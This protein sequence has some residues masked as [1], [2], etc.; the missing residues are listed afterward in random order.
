MNSTWRTE[1]GRPD[2]RDVPRTNEVLFDP[3]RHE[4]LTSVRWNADA[5]RA[6]IAAIVDD[7]LARFSPGKLW[8]TH[9]L[10]DEDGDPPPPFTMLYMGAAGVMWALDWLA[11]AGATERRRNFTPMLDDLAARN[12]AQVEPWGH[13]VESLFMGRAGILLLHD[14]L[15][16]SPAIADRLAAS[17][18]ANAN[19]PS[20]ELL[21]GSPG[22]MHAAL[23]MHE[24]TGEDRWADLFRNDART[25]AASFAYVP[26]A[27]CRLWTQDL[28]G[29]HPQYIG[30]GHGF[31]G[32]ASALIRGGALLP[33]DEWEQWVEHIVE[34]TQ[35]MA[36]HDGAQVLAGRQLR[37][38]PAVFRMGGELR[39]DDG[40]KHARAIFHDGRR[41]FVA[42][43]FDTQD[44]GH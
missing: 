23:A 25:L 1:H 29:E 40:R 42:R 17:I 32:N 26:A 27:R 41:R 28:Y 10:D 34:T 22:T 7:T 6:A 38:H 14:R 44:P 24:A 18:A 4:K 21:W 3:R 8:P 31:A 33:P 43:G 13:G 16:P 9:P 15:A 36:R 20:L 35:A 5:A 12:L 11:R 30:A 37:H 19:H 39:G 2:L